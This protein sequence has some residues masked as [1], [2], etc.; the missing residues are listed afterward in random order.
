MGWGEQVAAAPL[1]ALALQ[2]QV[3]AVLKH[4]QQAMA[5]LVFVEEAQAIVMAHTVG[6]A[7][8]S[9]VLPN[10][11]RAERTRHRAAMQAIGAALP[12]DV[13]AQNVSVGQ[14]CGIGDCGP[15]NHHH[16]GPAACGHQRTFVA[17]RLETT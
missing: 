4:S 15:V 13:T 17:Q 9:G 3:N 5:E 12:N 7:R 6:A 2:R 11:I 8:A 14:C 16:V 10:S 1:A